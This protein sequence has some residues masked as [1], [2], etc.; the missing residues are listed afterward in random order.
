MFRKIIA[1]PFGILVAFITVVWVFSSYTYVYIRGEKYVKRMD[2]LMAV[3]NK[4][5]DFVLEQDRLS[6]YK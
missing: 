5:M 4:H 1:L 2:D 6:K 3:M